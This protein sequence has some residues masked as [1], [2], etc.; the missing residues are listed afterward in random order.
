MS[1][2]SLHYD[3]CDGI[4]STLN[5]HA[6]LSSLAFSVRKKPY[7]RG[8]E[9]VSGG[10]VCPFGMAPYGDHEN[11]RY[12]LNFKVLVTVAF[13]SDGD[14]VSNIVSHVGAIELV[15]RIFHNKS[16]GFMPATLRGVNTTWSTRFGANKPTLEKTTTEPHTV[17]VDPAFEGNW[18]VCA[19]VLYCNVLMPRLD[20]SSL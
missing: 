5:N 13:P 18:D 14:L 1:L 8:R 2:D 9:F 19:V 7:K 11:I 3:L 20:Y 16:H 4:K 6:D 10:T 15:H 12:E 17:F